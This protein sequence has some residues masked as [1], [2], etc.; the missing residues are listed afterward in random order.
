MRTAVVALRLV[1][2]DGVALAQQACG[3]A[4]DQRNV[5]EHAHAVDVLARLDVVQGVE[6]NIEGLE[7]EDVELGIHDI[8]VLRVNLHILSKLAHLLGQCEA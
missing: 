2:E 5:R 8:R 3:A 7:E 6:D 1:R 4:L